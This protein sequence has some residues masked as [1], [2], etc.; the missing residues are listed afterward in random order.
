MCIR[1]TCELSAVPPELSL[2]ASLEQEPLV[3][4]VRCSRHGSA[5]APALGRWYCFC[6]ELSPN[7]LCFLHMVPAAF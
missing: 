1:R 7:C 4:A 5:C 2:F 6:R 3:S